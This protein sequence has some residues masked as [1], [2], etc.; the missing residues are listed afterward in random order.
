MVGVLRVLTR[1]RIAGLWSHLHVHDIRVRLKHAIAYMER[2]L[3]PDLC[4]LDGHHGFFQA[5]GRIV[6]LHLF[7]Q[8]SRMLLGGTHR[9]QRT[10]KCAGK[11]SVLAVF[12][13]R[14]CTPCKARSHQWV[15]GA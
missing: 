1:G 14:C 5:D 4:F 12:F 9:L 13:Q 7:L 8:C 15:R 10:L 6:K 3:E 11:T 2:G